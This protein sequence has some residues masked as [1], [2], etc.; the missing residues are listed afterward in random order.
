MLDRKI[1]AN[2]EQA[3]LVMKKLAIFHATNAVHYQK[4]EE[5]NKYFDRLEI[6]SNKKITSPEQLEK[7]IKKYELLY[8][9]FLATVSSI[10]GCE[11]GAATEPMKCGLK[12]LNHGDAWLNNMLFK[13]DENKTV[14]DS[15]F[16]SPASD[17]IYFIMSSVADDVKTANLDDLIE[18]Y[19][20]E[21]S[22]NLKI[23]SYDQKI[24][25]LSEISI[26]LLEKV[27][28]YMMYVL[29]IIKYNSNDELNIEILMDA[30][31]SNQNLIQIAFNNEICKAAL[32]IWIPF[33]NKRG[34]LD[35][36]LPHAPTTPFMAA[37]TQKLMQ[38]YENNS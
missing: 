18:I 34:F 30:E 3:K 20:N 31:K 5:I 19:H 11:K 36:L 33:L 8:K 22:R 16:G 6:L 26:D 25:T 15:F 9:N 35:I 23:C 27:A 2:F 10:E 37:L 14:I 29:I 13:F 1:G 38:N 17:L 4:V 32:K 24:P 12:V 21:L 7:S 28:F